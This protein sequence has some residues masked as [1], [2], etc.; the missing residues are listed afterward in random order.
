MGAG[1]PASSLTHWGDIGQV[2]DHPQEIFSERINEF[3]FFELLFPTLAREYN[4]AR[5]TGLLRRLSVPAPCS[6][7][8]LG[9]RQA[10]R[11]CSGLSTRVIVRASNVAHC[12]VARELPAV[13]V[14]SSL[15]QSRRGPCSGPG[16]PQVSQSASSCQPQLAGDVPMPVMC[17]SAPRQGSRVLQPPMKTLVSVS[18]N[19]RGHWTQSQTGKRTLPASTLVERGLCPPPR[20]PLTQASV[21][22][23][24][25]PVRTKPRS[26]PCLRQ[27]SSGALVPS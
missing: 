25:H 19:V 14:V 1:D 18:L 10:P 9:P 8:R 23:D 26:L 22:G 17:Q 16:S 2:L 21:K 4:N 5:L 12:L 24:A 6:A 11:A 20:P 15:G 13:R 3:N 27:L 7:R